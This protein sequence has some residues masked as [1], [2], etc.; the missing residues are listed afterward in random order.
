MPNEFVEEPRV[1]P[2]KTEISNLIDINL[3]N[4]LKSTVSQ[5]SCRQVRLFVQGT[6]QDAGKKYG[7]YTDVT[8]SP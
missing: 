8:I 7:A 3:V 1:T 5:V 2:A 4:V 6:G